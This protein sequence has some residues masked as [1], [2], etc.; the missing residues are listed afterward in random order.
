MTTSTDL[1]AVLSTSLGIER[2]VVL[3]VERQRKAAVQ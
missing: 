1:C 3:D 2:E